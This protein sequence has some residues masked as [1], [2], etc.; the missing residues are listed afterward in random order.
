MFL[1]LPLELIYFNE[2]LNGMLFFSEVNCSF[3]AL[4]EIKS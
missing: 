3:A 4:F 1:P 2:S